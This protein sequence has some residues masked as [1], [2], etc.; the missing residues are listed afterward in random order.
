MKLDW[1]QLE[2]GVW[3]ASTPEGLDFVIEETSD[4][5][6]GETLYQASQIL[7]TCCTAYENRIRRF[8]SMEEARAFLENLAD[9]QSGQKNP[10]S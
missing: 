1:K 10:R 7:H 5:A 2:P 3:G 4:G 8:P 9:V 6:T